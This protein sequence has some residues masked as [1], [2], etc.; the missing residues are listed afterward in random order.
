MIAYVY[1]DVASVFIIVDGP[2]SQYTF[3]VTPGSTLYGLFYAW[4]FALP[5][6]TLVGIN[7]DVL[8]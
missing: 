1:P 5:N 4:W 8:A 2:Y 7:E 6:G 3:T